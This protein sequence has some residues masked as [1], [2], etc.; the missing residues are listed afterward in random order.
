[1]EEEEE[2]EE[3]EE[4]RNVH[5]GREDECFRHLYQDFEDAG[6]VGMI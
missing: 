4:N 5:E 6:R 3:E 2:E 1:M